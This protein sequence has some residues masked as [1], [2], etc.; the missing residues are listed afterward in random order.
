VSHIHCTH[1]EKSTNPQHET[2]TTTLNISEKQHGTG[3]E[4]TGTVNRDA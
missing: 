4:F 2:R 3:N 1:E